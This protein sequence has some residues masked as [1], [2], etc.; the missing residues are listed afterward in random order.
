LFITFHMVN[1]EIS[2]LLTS[3]TVV[4]VQE[5]NKDVEKCFQVFVSWTQCTLLLMVHI[6][7]MNVYLLIQHLKASEMIQESIGFAIQSW[8]IDKIV[9]SHQL[10]VKEEVL[11]TRVLVLWN[12]EDQSKVTGERLIQQYYIDSDEEYDS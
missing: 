7:G 4:L 3:I 5:L 2:V 6:D 11:E 8:R 10:N 9:V 1:Q 12:S